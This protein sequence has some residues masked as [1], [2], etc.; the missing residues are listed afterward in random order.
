MFKVQYRKRSREKAL[1]VEFAYNTD[2][3]TAIIMLENKI[4]M[5]DPAKKFVGVAMKSASDEYR[6]IDGQK[7]ALQRAVAEAKLPLAVREKI[8][9]EF[10]NRYVVNAE[11]RKFAPNGNIVNG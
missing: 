9:K 5:P 6:R 3:T 2:L 7:I 1:F 8:W 11:R 10:V 4:K